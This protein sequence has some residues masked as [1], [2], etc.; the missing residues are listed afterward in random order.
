MTCRSV[1]PD[2]SSLQLGGVARGLSRTG[3]AR[4]SRRSRSDLGSLWQGLLASAPGGRVEPPV[5]QLPRFACVSVTVMCTAGITHQQTT[6]GSIIVLRG[7]K[8]QL[9]LPGR[10]NPARN[11][12]PASCGECSAG[13]KRSRVLLRCCCVRGGFLLMVVSLG[14]VVNCRA[15]G[16]LDHLAVFKKASC[17]ACSP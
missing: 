7:C 13:A 5:C 1:C 8:S 15:G 17:P 2:T 6:A 4:Q 12:S 10:G 11:L 3:P 9:E 14:A 16:Y